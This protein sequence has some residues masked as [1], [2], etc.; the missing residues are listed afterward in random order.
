MMPRFFKDADVHGLYLERVDEVTREAR[1]RGTAP[2]R[3]DR[4][5]IAVF[6]IDVQVAFCAPGA[7][8]FV[9]G[10]PEDNLRA[11]R[12][13]YG[14]LDR[15]T[16]LIFSLDTHRVFQIFHPAWWQDEAGRSPAPL[17]AITHADVVT[18]K[19]RPTRF[20]EESREY[21]RRLEEGR[22][23]VLTIWPYHAMLGGISHALVPAMTELSMFHSI[24]RDTQTLLVQKGEEPLTES[25]SVLSPE[26]GGA[27]NEDLF[28]QLMQHDKLYVFGQAKSHCVLSTLG[29]LMARIEREDR[30]LAKKVHILV[31][32]MSPVPA[33]DFPAKA[34][35]GMRE[36]ESKGMRLVRTSDAM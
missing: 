31:D 4:E 24:A 5:K 21:V 16:T 3:E 17:T 15:L 33:Q 27:F 18:G 25:Y 7:S 1:E 28:R 29:D 11:L 26:V 14:N 36:L 2:A 32:A 19:W 13:L 12:F 8:L 34:D 30:G 22:R 20:P 23:Y 10:A 6:G 9:P 35:E